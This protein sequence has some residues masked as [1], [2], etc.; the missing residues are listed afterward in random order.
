MPALLGVQ[1]RAQMVA[2]KIKQVQ[3]EMFKLELVQAMNGHVASDLVPGSDQTYGEQRQVYTAGLLKIQDAY[4]DL[5][6][7]IRGAARGT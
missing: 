6:D 4:P 3:A 1:D 2:E 7:L 5:V